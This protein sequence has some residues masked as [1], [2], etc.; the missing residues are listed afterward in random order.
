MNIPSWRFRQARSK[1]NRDSQSRRSKR[2]NDKQVTTLDHLKLRNYIVANGWLCLGHQARQG[3]QACSKY[4]TSYAGRGRLGQYS[5][6]R[7]IR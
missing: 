3:G 7:E 2:D 5:L 1:W 4:S 6:R